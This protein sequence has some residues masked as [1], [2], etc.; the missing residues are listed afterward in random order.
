MIV[1]PHISGLTTAEG[2]VTGFLECLAALEGGETPR[3]VVDRD[4]GY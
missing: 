3:W 2:A 4:R 1:S